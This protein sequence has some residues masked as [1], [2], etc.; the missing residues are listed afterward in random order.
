MM[1]IRHLYASNRATPDMGCE[2]GGDSKWLIGNY[3]VLTLPVSLD[4]IGNFL[5]LL[6]AIL[7]FIV[8][9]G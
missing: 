6:W 5:G 2:Y 4:C 7:A 9:I 1:A 8:V 3:W